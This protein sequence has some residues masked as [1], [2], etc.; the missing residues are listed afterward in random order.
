[1]NTENN[2]NIELNKVPENAM[3]RMS[4]KFVDGSA[5]HKKHVLQC[6]KDNGQTYEDLVMYKNNTQ[7]VILAAFNS[8]KKARRF[9]KKI[10]L[11]QKKSEEEIEEILKMNYE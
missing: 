1:M 9:L 5:T 3:F 8:P 6:S 4:R 7:E 11:A 2:I 10:L